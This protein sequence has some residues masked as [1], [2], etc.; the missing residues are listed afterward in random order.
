MA[1]VVV[2]AANTNTRVN[3][4]DANTNWGNFNTG[5][6]SP[7]SE[8]Q[9]RYQYSGTGAV[10]IVNKKITSTSSRTGIDYDPGSGALDMTAAAN[11]LWL[12]KC[13]IA[14]FGDLDAT[15]GCEL[16]LGSS[17]ANYYSYNAAGTGANR[18]VFDTYPAQGGHLILALDPNISAWREGTTGT[19]VLTAVDYFAFAAQFVT[20]GAKSENVGLDAIDI[21][22]GL[23]LYGGDGVSTDGV[24]QDFV[25]ADQGTLANRW[26]YV[27]QISGAIIVR[28][29][30]EIGTNNVTSTATEFT[31]D[32]GTTVFF[33]DGYHSAGLFGVTV[34]LGSAS[35]V[36]DI[37]SNLIGQGA[38]TTE[39]T[40]PDHIVTGTSGTYAFSGQ[41]L[42]HRNITFTS[43]VDCD[44][45]VLECKLLTQASAEIQNS[46]IRTNA[47]ASVACLQDPTFGTTTDLHDTTFEQIGAGHALEIDTATSYTF[48]NLFFNGYGADTTDSS[49]LDIT[50]SSGTVT[51]TVSGGDTPTY[52]TAGATV[53]INAD[54]TVTFSNLKDNSEV[55]VYENITVED[56]DISFTATDTIS[57][58]GSGFG[59]FAVDDIVRISGSDSNDDTYTVVTASASTLTVTP[60]TITT[61]SAGAT[62]KIKKINQTEL[63]GIEDATAGSPDERTFAASIASGTLVDYV[64]HNFQPGDEVYQTIRVIEFTWPSAVQTIVINQ[65]IDRN[66][67]N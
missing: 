62:V 60:A 64:I 63:A 15:Y 50:A 30:L 19:P 13:I 46:T 11:K 47:A 14:D 53:V 27:T 67:E 18:S 61:E 5:G 10:G 48:T 1:I 21:G 22:T 2:T 40:R 52:K 36:I 24:F 6:G 41:L 51:I 20:G 65:Q 54:V 29:M 4:S 44:G 9:L 17:N 26:G 37:S 8:P 32:S 49:A 31:D 45:A 58:A 25:D 16:V 55:R 56:T 66:V 12:V 3:D 39:D 38:E 57:S 43:G 59:D 28:G 33:P 23:Q 7:A 34:D 35:T 42:N